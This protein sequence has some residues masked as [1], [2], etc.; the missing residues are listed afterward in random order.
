MRILIDIGHPAHILYFKNLASYFIIKGNEVLFTCREKEVVIELLDSFGFDYKSI[1]KPYK[2]IL[3]KIKGLVLF[4]IRLINISKIFK[5]DIFLSA[6][7]IYASHASFFFRRPHITLEDTFNM[8]QVR[9]YMPFSSAVITGKYKHRPLGWKEISYNG[10]QE[11]A[12]LHPKYFTPDPLIIKDLSLKDDERYFI[13]RFV[14]WN[15]SHDFGEKGLPF[16]IKIKIV[17][18]LSRYGKVFISSENRLPEIF[19]GLKFPLHPEKMHH[20][21]AYADLYVG[22]GATMASECAMLGT[23]AIYINSE[24]AGSIDEQERMGM[25]DHF[26]NVDGLLEKIQILL[27]TPCLK[28]NSI[29]RSMKLIDEKIDVT[30]FLTWFIEKWPGSFKIMKDDP[31]YDNRFKIKYKG[32]KDHLERT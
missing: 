32:L 11:L 7:S 25:I 29:E 20:A 9:L 26:R 14:S 23:H 10:Y 21:L 1:G 27:E 4:D 6:G 28:S 12:Y 22:E 16:E 19:E 8:E 31:E 2:S 18:L 17:E 15:A 24:E 3:W 5:P 13:I 30:S